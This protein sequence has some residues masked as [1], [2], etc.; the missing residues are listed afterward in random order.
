MS[1][2]LKRLAAPVVLGIPRKTTV[3]VARSAPGP[4]PLER[5]VPLIKVL[6][7][8]LKYC[9]YADEGKKIIGSRK[10][11]VDGK[12]VTDPKF[13]VGLM[14]VVSMPETKEYYRML[15]DV[16]G[17]LRLVKATKEDAAWK[18]ARIENKCVVPGRKFQLN[19]HDGRNILIE[20]S[21]FK[22]GDVLK[23]GLPEQ[24][25]LAH[26]ELGSGAVAMLI[27][28]QHVGELATIKEYHI[29]RGTEPNIVQFNEGF[30]TVKE[31]VFVV[32]KGT[33]EVKMPEVALL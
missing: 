22:T 32:G 8:M 33:T 29:R 19:F 31:N 25:I 17:R 6:R 24:K 13:P 14:D 4:H 15:L 20:K 1:K 16:R 3:W 10:I 12:V 2:H 18:L 7:D 11:H 21:Q 30:T 5:S 27:G 26:Y 28:G 23:L 9:D